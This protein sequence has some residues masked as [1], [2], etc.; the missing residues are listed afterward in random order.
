[1]KLRPDFY[2]RQDV[3]QVAQDLLGTVLVTQIGPK[4]C[5]GMIVE[6][7]A[8]AGITDRASHAWNGRRTKRTEIMY[9]S[10]GVV[11][12]FLIYGIHALFNVVTG[13]QDVPHAVLI[14]AIEPTNGIKT[15]QKRRGIKTI[16]TNLTAGP[17]LLTQALGIT[18]THSGIDLQGE[19][20]W[21]EDG[22]K[23]SADQIMSSPRIGVAYAGEDALL[24]RRYCIKDNLWV[25]ANK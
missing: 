6:T 3:E 15:M 5:S 21:I 4:R 2:R 12:V 22:E 20:I 8:Y 1:M 25:S 16:K 9:H 11:Y 19:V 17:G 14:R 24:P 13:K 7:E 10:G 18:T 23:I